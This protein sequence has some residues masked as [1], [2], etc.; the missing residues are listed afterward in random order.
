MIVIENKNESTT[1]G[2]P[3]SCEYDCLFGSDVLAII[4]TAT[5]YV[6]A[7]IFVTLIMASFVWIL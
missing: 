4:F 2:N 3:P 5:M 6:F 7:V 1:D